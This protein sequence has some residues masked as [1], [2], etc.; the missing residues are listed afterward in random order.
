MKHSRFP[1]ARGVV[2]SC[3]AILLCSLAAIGCKGGSSGGGGGGGGVTPP[4]GGGAN[5]TAP[6]FTSS[7]ASPSTLKSNETLNL[8]ASATDGDGDTLSYAWSQTAGPSF[9]SIPAGANVSLTAPAVASS[10]TASFKIVVSDGKGGIIEQ[11]HNVTVNPAGGGGPPPPP[12]P[13]PGLSLNGI[14]IIQMPELQQSSI[15]RPTNTSGK[16]I[17]LHG[18]FS[19]YHRDQYAL[20]YDNGGTAAVTS[21]RQVLQGK[22]IAWAEAPRLSMTGIYTLYLDVYDTTTQTLI[23]T[24]EAPPGGRP[25]ISYSDPGTTYV[26]FNGEDGTINNN[27]RVYSFEVANDGTPSNNRF[28]ASGNGHVNRPRFTAAGSQHVFAPGNAGFDGLLFKLDATKTSGQ[29]SPFDISAGIQRVVMDCATSTV[30]NAVLLTQTPGDVFV[31]V[32]VANDLSA[33]AITPLNNAGVGALLAGTTIAGFDVIHYQEHNEVASDYAVIA[34]AS[35]SDNAVYLV[36]LKDQTYRR[37]DLGSFVPQAMSVILDQ[38]SGLWLIS[39]AGVTSGTGA[40]TLTGHQFMT[41]KLD[42]L[43]LMPSPVGPTALSSITANVKSFHVFWD[44][45]NKRHVGWVISNGLNVYTCYDLTNGG[46]QVVTSVSSP[47]STGPTESLRARG[48]D[49]FVV[50]YSGA[51]F[52]ALFTSW[53]GNT[54]VNIPTTD[55][56]D[57]VAVGDQVIAVEDRHS[58]GHLVKVYHGPTNATVDHM[59]PFSASSNGG[60]GTALQ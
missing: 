48:M 29:L 59:P 46:A 18:D 31:V 10:Q 21:L 1:A 13:P 22:A 47:S 39:V 24:A 45:A 38:S 34:T 26:V 49:G 53:D 32:E 57:A 14:S 42:P 54:T 41:I 20:R 40:A 30:G 56:P 52:G 17:R 33:M 37:V 35:G 43:I 25:V 3:L 5:N 27:G 60:L 11:T 44:A 19:S 36:R 16:M 58:T 4:P 6:A 23:R 9:G 28:I 55:A 12:P 7:T 2:G 15:T 51:A 8:H 50:C